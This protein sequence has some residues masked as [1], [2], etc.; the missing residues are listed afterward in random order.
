MGIRQ[1]VYECCFST[2]A[3]HRA[4]SRLQFFYDKADFSL[5]SG[6]LLP[7]FPSAPLVVTVI[8][9]VFNELAVLPVCLARLRNVLDSLSLSYELLFVDDGSTDG[10]S[11]YLDRVASD[12][13]AVRVIHLS[14]NFGKEA[15]MTAGL[16]YARGD[17]VIILDADM[18]D[19]PE[20]IPDMI[21]AWRAGSDV[22]VMRR[23]T[24]VG[25][26]WMK[27]VSAHLYYR[28]LNRLSEVAIPPDTGDFRLLSRRAVAAMRSMTERSR[29]MKG[30]FAWIG[31]PTTTILYDRAPRAAGKSKW[32]LANLAKLGFDGITSFSLSPLRI[33]SIAG[34]IILIIGSVL[35]LFV[36]ARALLYGESISVPLAFVALLAFLSGLQLSTIGVL[37]TYVGRI[38]TEIKQRPVYLIQGIVERAH[39]PAQQRQH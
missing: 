6:A 38:H 32:G 14:R 22:V 2:T 24:R 21:H 17:A 30:L 33:A 39:M 18:Q 11:L 31:M 27:R 12:M 13:D 34:A 8:I 16:D 1:F 10:T 29:Y 35:G 20:L 23:R 7:H 28:I 15:A 36:I 3:D 4:R 26:T 5:M 19:P 25:D 37:G 9:P